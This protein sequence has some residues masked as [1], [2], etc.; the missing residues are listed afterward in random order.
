MNTQVKQVGGN[1]YQQEYQL[2]DFW[3]DTGISAMLGTPIKYLLRYH[4]KNGLEDLL[5]A[6]SYIERLKECKNNSLL[7]KHLEITNLNQLVD[8]LI[9]PYINTEKID[10]L[11]LII[12]EDLLIGFGKNNTEFQIKKILYFLDTVIKEYTEKSNN[13]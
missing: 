1:H 13:E 12:V 4:N 7:C 2:W 6:R 8:K 5:K 10:P 3:C 11:V 9:T